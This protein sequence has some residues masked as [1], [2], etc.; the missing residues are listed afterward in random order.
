MKK[1]LLLMMIVLSTQLMYPGV[2]K[3]QHSEIGFS[4][5]LSGALL[6]GPYYNYWLDDNQCVEA[7]LMAAWE[8]EFAFPFAFNAGYH[9]YLGEKNWRPGLGLQ[10]SLFSPP[11][12]KSKPGPFQ[13]S[14]LTLL[15]G[16]QYRWAHTQ[17]DTRMK[18]WISTFLSKEKVTPWRVMPIGLQLDYGHKLE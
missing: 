15:P 4:I 9:Y 7:S 8:L 16:V 5:V 2:T 11:R 14:L 3:A 17:Q 13:K 6:F 1:F 10:Y 18:I 12:D